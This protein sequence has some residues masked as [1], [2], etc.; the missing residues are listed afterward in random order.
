ML[1]R[2]M[3]FGGA[4]FIAGI[5]QSHA[6]GFYTDGVVLHPFSLQDP[7][8]GAGFQNNSVAAAAFLNIDSSLKLTLGPQTLAGYNYWK[9]VNE[10]AVLDPAHF[11]DI[12]GPFLPYQI[13]LDQPFIMGVVLF[14]GGAFP[15]ESPADFDSDDRFGWARL[16]YTAADG[17]TL[18]DS[19]MAENGAGII[20]GTTTVLP[21][22]ST[23]CLAMSTT[24]GR[25]LLRRRCCKL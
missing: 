8:I 4:I 13:T 15:P 18:I 1:C 16:K 17:L 23:I 6:Q 3:I 2:A 25:I 21:E 12:R 10:G 20:A 22:P 19:A 9:V 11:Q 5:V 24:I 14:R 7:S